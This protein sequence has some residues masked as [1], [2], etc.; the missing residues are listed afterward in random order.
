MREEI[1]EFINRRFKNDNNWLD[2]NCYY[3]AL[4][5]NKRFNLPIYYCPIEGH[6]IVVDEV[7]NTGY[8]YTGE[9]KLPYN[10]ISFEKLEKEDE[11]WFNYIVR[12]CIM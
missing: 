12:D 8:D 6:F 10:I 11:L 9:I 1:I 5:L 2:G 7:T 3:F 4:I